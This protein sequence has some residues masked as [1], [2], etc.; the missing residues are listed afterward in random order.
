MERG[1]PDRRKAMREAMAAMGK[2]CI[3]MVH[4]KGPGLAELPKQREP[5]A[6][7]GTGGLWKELFKSPDGARR[8]T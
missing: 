2:Q 8:M 1:S 7:R 3:V 6:P 4:R 5:L